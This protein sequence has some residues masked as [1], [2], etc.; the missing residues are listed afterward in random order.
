MIAIIDYGAGNL[1]SV[2]KAFQHVGVPAAVTSKKEDI[3]NARGI[4]LPGVGAF[5]R[6]MENLHRSGLD[7]VVKEAIAGGKPFLGICLGLQLLFTESEEG[8]GGREF[9]RGLD[10][11][12]GRVRRF[13]AGLKVPQIGWNQLHFRRRVPLFAGVEEGAYVYFVHSYYVEP[14]D[15]AV[16]A[17]TTDYGI[18]FV[19]SVAWKNVWA[20]QF[21]PEKSSRVGL[22]ILRNFGEWVKGGSGG[23][24]GH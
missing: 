20:I 9:P 16:V 5:G 6:A 13:P 3:K 21:H 10:I 4:V 17:T 7:E 14:A 18:D 2:E 24:S 23:N 8:F 15:E 11:L 12:S 19:S 1:R 22:R